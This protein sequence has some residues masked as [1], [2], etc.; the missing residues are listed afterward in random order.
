VVQVGGIVLYPWYRKIHQTNRLRHCLLSGHGEAPRGKKKHHRNETYR[1]RRCRK[2]SASLAESKPR[3]LP[4]PGPIRISYEE[5]HRTCTPF[6]SKPAPAPSAS[7]ATPPRTG[8]LRLYKASETSS[9]A[10]GNAAETQVDSEHKIHGLDDRRR[11]ADPIPAPGPCRPK[12][13]A[14][15]HSVSL[16]GR[17]KGTSLMIGG[18]GGRGKGK[19]QAEVST[20]TSHASICP[21]RPTRVPDNVHSRRA[22]LSHG[23]R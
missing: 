3:N 15:R 5:G 23:Q 10:G 16:A 12:R 8:K 2:R 19:Q 14:G 11:L 20:N 4:I 17:G 22:E 1:E 18:R 13:P 7:G 21:L 9:S 6:S